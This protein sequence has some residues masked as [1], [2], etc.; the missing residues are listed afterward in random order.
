MA[1]NLRQR[2]PGGCAVELRQYGVVGCRRDELAQ[3][4]NYLTVFAELMT[5]KSS[6][7]FTESIPRFWLSLLKNVEVQHLS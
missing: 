2:E 1:D 5:K 4:N 6:L 7:L 3:G